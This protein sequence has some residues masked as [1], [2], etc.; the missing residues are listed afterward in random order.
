[1]SATH[2]KATD[3]SLRTSF[4]KGHKATS[5]ALPIPLIYVNRSGRAFDYL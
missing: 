5:H 4:A 3:T 1:M 2:P